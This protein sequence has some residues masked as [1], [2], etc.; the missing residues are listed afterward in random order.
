MSPRN[1]P[2]AQFNFLVEINGVTSAGFSEVT[3][4]NAESDIIEYRE[5]S[6]VSR[7][8]KLPG[9]SKYGDITLKRGH[10][11]NSELWDWRQTTLDGA[12]ERRNGAIV[13]LDEA[14]QPQLRW[15]FFEGWLSKYTPSPMNAATNEAA[16]EEIVLVYEYMQQV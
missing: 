10:T 12:T 1:D 2:F 14:R 5:G 11:L 9:L 8:R 13:L 15:E 3:G 4:M 16:L 7:V 6:D